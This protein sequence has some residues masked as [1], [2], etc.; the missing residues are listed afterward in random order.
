MSL[1]AK[2]ILEQLGK[3]KRSEIAWQHVEGY[4]R[5]QYGTLDHLD[6]RTFNREVAI[7]VQCIDNDPAQAKMLA[8]SFGLRVD[9][10]PPGA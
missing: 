2:T 3:L 5:C 8:E 4:M 7:A 1:Y 9:P 6:R 10:K